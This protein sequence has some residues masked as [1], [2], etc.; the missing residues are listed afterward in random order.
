MC[1]KGR[2]APDMTEARRVNLYLEHSG[3]ISIFISLHI[4]RL[5]LNVNLVVHLVLQE[6]AM[7]YWWSCHGFNFFN[8]KLTPPSFK[9]VYSFVSFYLSELPES[10]FFISSN[11]LLPKFDPRKEAECDQEI[12]TNYIW[13]Y[14][15][16]NGVHKKFGAN[17]NM[18]PWSWKLLQS[19]SKAEVRSMG[20]SIRLLSARDLW[21]LDCMYVITTMCM[22]CLFEGNHAQQKGQ[23]LLSAAVFSKEISIE[24]KVHIAMTSPGDSDSLQFVYFKWAR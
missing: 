19:L 20:A 11:C 1:S 16:D 14:F 9:L 13:N 6:Y 3:G 15:I 23:W 17:N 24:K 2:K 18:C 21:F 10:P 12:A 22:R 8:F 4:C 5:A 7:K